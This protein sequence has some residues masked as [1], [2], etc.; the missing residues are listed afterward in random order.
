MRGLKT[1]ELWKNPEYRKHMSEAHKGHK[2]PPNAY[3]FPKGSDNPVYNL[4]VVEKIRQSKI[5]E[6]NPMYGKQP[7]NWLGGTS[8]EPYSKD[9][10]NSLK[11]AIRK[12]D[13]HIC[14]ICNKKYENGRKHS[15]HHIDYNKKNCEINNLITLCHLCHIKTNTK[16]DY[17]ISFFNNKIKV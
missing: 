9:W 2:K 10:K 3:S 5:G 11:E 15:V 14:Q 16:R 13:N 4:D 12:R 1:K 17:W 8:F 6:K 7:W